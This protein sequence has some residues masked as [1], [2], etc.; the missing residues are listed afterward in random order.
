MELELELWSENWI[1]IEIEII[2]EME[3][4]HELKLLSENWIRIEIKKLFL[5]LK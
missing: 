4:E 3:L 2:F 1:T 5:E